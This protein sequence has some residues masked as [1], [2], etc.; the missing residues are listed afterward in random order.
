[1]ILYAGQGTMHF[2]AANFATGSYS[3]ITPYTS[4]VDEAIYFTDDPAVVDSFMTKYDD[5]WTDTYHYADLANVS[6]L[7]RN[8]PTYPIDAALNFPPTRT[9]RTAWSRRCA[10]KW[11]DSTW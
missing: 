9:T 2:S 11:P 6:T 3:P 7:V 10:P 8:Y 4:Y 5:L 1:M